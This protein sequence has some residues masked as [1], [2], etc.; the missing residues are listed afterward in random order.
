MQQKLTE[1]LMFVSH[2]SDDKRLVEQLVN[3]ITEFL[4]NGVTVK[5]TSIPGTIPSGEVK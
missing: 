4:A 2:A 3:I 1:N 5:A